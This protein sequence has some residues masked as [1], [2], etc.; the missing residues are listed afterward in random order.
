MSTNTE[1]V[2]IIDRSNYLKCPNCDA[3]IYV[4]LEPVPYDSYISI[5]YYVRCEC[6]N[7]EAKV[8]RLHRHFSEEQ[9]AAHY[10][11]YQSNRYIAQHNSD[12]ANNDDEPYYSDHED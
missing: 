1:S 5:H 3:E 12:L 9:L 6:C 11:Q 4:G 2:W 7:T 8:M 10:E